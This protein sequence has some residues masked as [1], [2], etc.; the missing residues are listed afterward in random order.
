[1]VYYGLVVT[2]NKLPIS[3]HRRQWINGIS[4][5]SWTCMLRS[6]CS[7][8]RFALAQSTILSKL[9]Q[10]CTVFMVTAAWFA[11]ST[12]C[13]TIRLYARHD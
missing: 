8:R 5:S 4:M 7:V 10:E 9:R 11:S 1:M 3:S 13:H 2:Q 12:H 6:K